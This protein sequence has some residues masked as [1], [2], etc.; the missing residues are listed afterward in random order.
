MNSFLQHYFLQKVFDFHSVV[1]EIMYEVITIHQQTKISWIT[2]SSSLHSFH[3]L[4]TQHTCD[5]IALA[6]AFRL[7]LLDAGINT[8]SSS[9]QRFFS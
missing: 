5:S 1:H 9:C 2:H 4:Y 7:D 6:S 3:T 8:H